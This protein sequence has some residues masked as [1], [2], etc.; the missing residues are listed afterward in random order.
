MSK[1]LLAYDSSIVGDFINDT[2]KT[3]VMN[4]FTFISLSTHLRYE[5]KIVLGCKGLL[6]AMAGTLLQKSTIFDVIL[7]FPSLQESY[8]SVL[9]MTQKELYHSR[10]NFT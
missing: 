9:K 7:L 8:E 6:Q 10:I 5:L 4:A 1:E 3:H 2:S